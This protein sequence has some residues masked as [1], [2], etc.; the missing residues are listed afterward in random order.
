MWRPA[1]SA[2]VFNK[3]QQQHGL[4][5]L[6]RD[7]AMRGMLP[8]IT[9]N[10][11][12]LPLPKGI[13]ASWH[14]HA[15]YVAVA[16]H[17]LGHNECQRKSEGAQF[18]WTGSDYSSVLLLNKNLETLLVGKLPIPIEDYRLFAFHGKLL[19]TANAVNRDLESQR[20]QWSYRVFELVL[21]FTR[22]NHNALQQCPQMLKVE[23]NDFE[24]NGVSDFDDKNSLFRFYGKNIG[25]VNNHKDGEL[26]L[27]W[28]LSN[29]VNIKNWTSETIYTDIRSS[30]L[31]NNGNPIYLPEYDT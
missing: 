18:E 1:T 30:D 14:P 23:L 15:H 3:I 16:R 17:F 27:L 7:V 19:I 2:T 26:K 24:Y 5:H 10:P 22:Q 25:L 12:M 21:N 29:P 11:A 28:R 13:A 4:E 6:F 9:Y 8:G 20:R 31:R